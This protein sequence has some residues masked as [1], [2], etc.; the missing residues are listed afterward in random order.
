M[1]Q[2]AVKEADLDPTVGPG[3]GDKGV[4]EAQSTLGEL[5]ARLCV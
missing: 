5:F 1:I 2:V 4:K 3:V